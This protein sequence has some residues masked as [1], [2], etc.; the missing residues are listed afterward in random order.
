MSDTR[1]A[2][3]EPRSHG[4]RRNEPLPNP[5]PATIR[6]LIVEDSQD[7]A[8]LIVREIERGGYRVVSER[9]DTREGLALALERSSWEVVLSDFSM[10]HFSGTEALRLVKAK[11]LDLPFIIVSGAVG[12]EAAVGAMRS[13]AHDYV[14][15][16]SLARLG[17][18]IE[19]ELREAS[20]RAERKKM[21]DQLLISDRMASVGTLAAGVAHELNNPL[22]A[23]L[24]NLELLGRDLSRF[25]DE[26]SL[27]EPLTDIF[28]EL[29]DA[30]ESASR[31]RHIVHDLK[32]FS[33]SA[34]DD[35]R[36]AVDVH[37]VLDSSL[38]MA[39]NEIR[40]RA[41]L[42]KEYGSVPL[43]QANE[44]RL[45]Q[46]FL[47]LVVNAAQS[48]VEGD[49][50][51]NQIRVSTRLNGP[52]MVVVEIADTGSGI[53]PKHLTRIFDAFFTTKPVGVGTG[54][55]LSI[56][57]RI[58]RS[59]GGELEVDSELGIGSH[60]RVVLPSALSTEETPADVA[61]PSLLATRRGRVLVVDDEPLIATAIGRTLGLDHDVVLASAA[62][63]ALERIHNGE[64]F[65]VIL[66]DLMMPQM[67]GMDLY[68]EL[69]RTA[70]GQAERVVFLSGGA[71]TAAAR[72]FLED[73]P[74]QRLEKPF[75]TRQLLALVND[76]TRAH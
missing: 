9:V 14:L 45:G 49:A 72:K 48:I 24:A 44:A 15:K 33:R 11:G 70:P 65:D 52:G 40:H 13:G 60:F 66:C 16:Q 41:L 46:V 5:S 10:P 47:N 17:P 2:A 12:E 74:N 42:V 53:A 29:G 63:T 73:V 23:L 32:L 50:D 71:F 76:R 27:S 8:E 1:R 22:A 30:R 55:G 67:T 3:R 62:A 36:G 4:P 18:A 58:V 59:L 19:R 26:R 7:D 51:H 31:M 28:A 38:R 57:H 21:H 69:V 37:R 54:L 75:D 6:V 35:R 68:G 25:A 64:E 43:V 34:D 20:S 61:P 39:H 56:C